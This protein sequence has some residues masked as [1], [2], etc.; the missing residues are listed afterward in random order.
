[1]WFKVREQTNSSFR[2]HQIKKGSKRLE[3]FIL[4]GSRRIDRIEYVG[5]FRQCRGIFSEFL[6]Y[7]LRNGLV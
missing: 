7:G 5:I 4:V 6:G 3:R 2:E 1:M